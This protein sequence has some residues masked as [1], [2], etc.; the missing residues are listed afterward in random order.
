MFPDQP[1]EDASVNHLGTMWQGLSGLRENLGKGLQEFKKE[2]LRESSTL[3]REVS[4]VRPVLVKENSAD[5]TGDGTHELDGGGPA[6][7]ILSVCTAYS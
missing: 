3:I 6:N 1:V 2:A 4:K 5:T 7:N